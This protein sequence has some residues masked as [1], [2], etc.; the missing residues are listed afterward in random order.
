VSMVIEALIHLTGDWGLASAL[1]FVLIV[2]TVLVL[3]VYNR[4]L[5][6]DR[7]AGAR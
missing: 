6:L 3:V 1:A 2:A 7:I 4:V 5:S